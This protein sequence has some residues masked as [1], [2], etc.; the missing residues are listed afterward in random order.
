MH[1]QAAVVMDVS[2]LA[3]PVHEVTHSRAGGA[4]HLR[5]GFLAQFQDRGSALG[6]LPNARQQQE[7]ARQALFAGVEELIYE[8]FLD[9]SDAGKK[10]VDDQLCKCRILMKYP[11]DCGCLDAC[12]RGLVNCSCRGHPQRPPDETT[13]TEE[14]AWPEDP[15]NGF[16]S[17]LLGRHRELH[18]AILDVE[19]RIGGIALFIDCFLVSVLSRHLSSADLP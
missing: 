1:L 15:D 5:K 18:I 12:D 9:S 7:N 17:A 10:V 13:L 19:H 4:D 16:S 8:V 11:H 2:H 6:S 14:V 3:E